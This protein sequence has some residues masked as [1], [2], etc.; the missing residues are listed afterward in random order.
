MTNIGSISESIEKPINAT[1]EPAPVGDPKQASLEAPST[2]RHAALERVVKERRWQE[3]SAEVGRITD[4]LG[5]PIDEGIK[6]TVVALNVLAI[7]TTQSCEG[8]PDWGTGSPWIDLAAKD[9]DDL[10]QR[11]RDAFA[12]ANSGDAQHFQPAD[13]AKLYEEAHRLRLE[14]SRQHLTEARK[15][16]RHLEAFYRDRPVPFDRRLTLQSFGSGRTRIESQGAM[17]QEV[18][19]YDSRQQKLVEY[20]EEMRAFTAF[21]K[22]RYFSGEKS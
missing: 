12:A 4:R 11:M 14:V 1:E 17:L 5:L 21:M 2:A 22:A 16:I 7:N 3:V 19:P 13:V 18:L 10:E 20:Q 15:V 8:H 9:S 6:E